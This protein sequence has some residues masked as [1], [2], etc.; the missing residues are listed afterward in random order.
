M[1]M[2]IHITGAAGSGTST[3]AAA[4]AAE[5]GGT[6]LEADDYFWL[7]TE[8]PYTARRDPSERLSQVLA[9][10]SMSKPAI[11][12]GA[13]MGWGAELEDSFDLIVFLY[14]DAA[15]RLQRLK[16]REVERFGRADPAFLEWAAQYDDGPPEGRSLAKHRAW[17]NARTCAV[18]EIH[19]DLSVGERVAMVRREASC[20]L[21]C[22]ISAGN[23]QRAIQA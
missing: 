23:P 16:A 12:A 17:L 1:I 4:L 20:L 14:L 21:V 6:H 8:R 15:V 22:A 5:L 11:L 3:V 19:G 2:R 7:A 13:V 18:V 9:D 10:V